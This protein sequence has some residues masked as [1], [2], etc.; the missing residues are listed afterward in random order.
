MA[1]VRGLARRGARDASGCFWIEGVRHFVQACDARLKFDTIVHSRILLKSDL[2]DMLARRLRGQG[3][4]CVRV[5]P[6]QF[7]SICTAQRASGIGAIVRQRWSPLLQLPIPP[8]AFFIVVEELRSP[9]NLGTI[10]RTA[11]AS[12]AAGIVF[13]SGRSDP[14][15]GSVVRASMGGIF[16]LPL[17]RA[18]PQQLRQWARARGVMLAGLSPEAATLWTDLPAG[19]TAILLGEER[20]G[21][22]SRLR[23]L[24]D[25]NVRLPMSGRADSLNV[26]VAAGVMIYE[27]V[28]RRGNAG[29][30]P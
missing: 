19:P 5:S 8:A 9:G 12:G 2:A 17:A 28:R 16:H 27:L 30:A 23:E 6:E 26:A 20:Q 3:V 13:V 22:S 14:F 7:R 11:E 21:L 25:V 4:P 1:R 10:L 29:S 18:T 15:D 24:C